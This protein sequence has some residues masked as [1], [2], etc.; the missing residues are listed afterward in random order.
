M[1]VAMA[2]TLLCTAGCGQK[3]PL[4]LP[5]PAPSA[6]PAGGGSPGEQTADPDRDAKARQQ[7]D[8][9][10]NSTAPPDSAH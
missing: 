9:S 6:V 10:G 8:A 5:D 2:L 7:H 3:G 4:Y 1:T